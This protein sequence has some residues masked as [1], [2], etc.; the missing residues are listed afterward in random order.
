[1][2]ETKNPTVKFLVAYHKPAVLLKDEIFTPIHVG[3]KLAQEITKDGFVESSDFDWMV[4]NMIGDDTGD[5][6]SHLNR[7]SS[8]TTGMYW[9]WK[10]Y[11]E[12]G[13]PDFI[14]FM[15]YRR[16]FSFKKSEKDFTEHA[17]LDEQYLKDIGYSPNKVRK[18][19][20][21]VDMIIPNK[22]V[23]RE[24]SLYEH[25]DSRQE[26]NISDLDI[27]LEVLNEKYPEFNKVAKKYLAGKE[28]YFCNM[29]IM[30]K[31][32]F[33]DYS[34]WLFD[35]LL[36]ADKR[37]DYSKYSVEEYR[38]IGHL[39]ERLTGIYITYL[40]DKKE[41]KYEA[42]P[43]TLVR[44]ADIK[45]DIKPAFEQNN[46]PICFS[47]DNYFSPHTGVAIKSI[48]ENSSPDKNYDIFILEENI[49]KHNKKKICKMIEGKDNFS[50]RFININCY[51]GNIKKSVFSINA[52]FR[53]ATYFRFFI[54]TIFKNF[55]KVLYLDADMIM[56]DDVSKIFETDLGDN[57]LAAVLDT[58][59]MRMIHVD[60]HGEH[61]RLKY[62]TETLSIERPDKYFQAGVIL[63][64]VVQMIEEDIQNKC[65]NK[66]LQIRTPKYVDQ[67]ILNSVCQ[68]RVSYLPGE[69]NVE[70][71]IPIFARNLAA[72]LP[73][74]LYMDY[75]EHRENPKIIHY[76]GWKKPW[77][78]P[79]IDLADYWWEYAK[80]SP[81][82]EHIL[83]N[84]LKARP[85][86]ADQNNKKLKIKIEFKTLN[87]LKY[88]I[89][90]LITSGKK[91]KEYRHKRNLIRDEIRKS[92]GMSKK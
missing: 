34:K 9:A 73:I 22:F 45:E 29:F 35:I 56:L 88:I 27:A 51:I 13:N 4:E 75:L 30:K 53:I 80:V 48:I 84:C 2:T 44:N 5:N 7:K 26:V 63:F 55:D 24:N 74:S 12:L 52:H 41:T 25:Y 89:L 6:I 71:Q 68:G 19:L 39:A 20:K 36:E 60:K 15:H 61:E 70:W 49:E 11:E 32:L 16:H 59:M 46:F 64:N 78:N 92:R 58:E 66:L 18:I 79:Q 37:I 54:P 40:T 67:D 50:I 1:M 10:H 28:A 72:E 47:A 86:P 43:L 17:Y 69:W 81:F 3:R 76:C 91:Q 83:Y 82:Y 23:I 14:G 38:L 65:I 90:S 33:F 57:I 31:E 8:E 62:L 87:Y 42:Y 85:V 21:N 77:D